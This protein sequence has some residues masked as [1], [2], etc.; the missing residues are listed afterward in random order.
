M[1]VLL[2][3]LAVLLVFSFAAEAAAQNN[4]PFG[5]GGD[6]AA[7]PF[8]QPRAGAQPDPFSPP[9]AGAVTQR[10]ADE[11]AARRSVLDRAKRAIAEGRKPVR[12]TPAGRTEIEMKIE[13]T[14]DQ[15][16]TQTFIETPLA[17]A[18]SQLSQ[19]HNIPIVIDNRAL[20]EIGLSSEVPT[21]IS[22]KNVTLR[23][24]LRLML[25][26]LE[27]TYLI[28]NEVLQ[29]TT[30]EAAEDNLVL[31]MYILPENLVDKSDQVI[32]VLTRM[33]VPDAWDTLGGPS[34]AMAIDHVLVISAT[35]DV[36]DQSKQFLG[37][38]VEKYGK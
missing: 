37:M 17:E 11:G 27:L 35:S 33:V 15:E 36:Q 29:I 4:D 20:E 21:M 31:E 23:S 34:S 32:K 13:A 30:M 6:A 18:I 14:L 24:F 3:S 19:V 12:V 38:L 28:D 8:A 2:G 1:R 25:R 16:T 7:D 26:D 9:R 5:G 10:K 22:L